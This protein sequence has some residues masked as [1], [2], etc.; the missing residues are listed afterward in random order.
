LLAFSQA[1]GRSQRQAA[2][3]AP[4]S[5]SPAVPSMRPPPA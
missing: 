3:R 5:T 2:R 4:P 1:P